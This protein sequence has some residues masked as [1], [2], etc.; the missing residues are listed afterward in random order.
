MDDFI[1]IEAAEVPKGCYSCNPSNVF[2]RLP[3]LQSAKGVRVM[4]S[5]SLTDQKKDEIRKNFKSI[6]KEAMFR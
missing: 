5:A 3:G 1:E 2:R 4:S 6:G